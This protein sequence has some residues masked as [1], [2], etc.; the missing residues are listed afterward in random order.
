[1][2]IH[3]PES[4]NEQTHT[5]RLSEYIRVE[6]GTTRAVQPLAN[7]HSIATTPMSLN[8]SALSDFKAALDAH[9][10]VAIT[11]ANGKITYANDKFCAISKYSRKELLGKDHRLINSGH[12]SKEYI[13]DL[14]DTI[15]SGQIWKGE[16]KNRAKDGSTYW[17]DTTIV[18]FLDQDGKPTQYIAIRAEITE[19][20]QLE[21]KN[22]AIM[23]EL[24]AVNKELTNFA[25]VVSHDLKAPL[26]GISSLAGWL[27][28][29]Y[30]DQLGDEGKKQ[31]GLMANRV[32]R[33]NGLI[34]G[35][36]TYSRAGRN[37]EH[38]QTVDLNA[39]LHNTI[40]LLAPPP[41][42]A[43]QIATP[44]PSISMEP[45]KAQQIFQ[46]LLS[47]AIKF[48]DKPA[49]QILM[50]CVREGPS[51]HVTISDNGP[52]IESKYFD[53]I[54]EL[55]QT[56]N[57]RDALESTGVGLSIVKKILELEHQ[58]I[59]VESTP[60]IGTTFHFTL[61]CMTPDHMMPNESAR[62]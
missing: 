38:R 60:G 15:K 51:C 9:A 54:F 55:F 13:R 6:N 3:F 20:K 11:D 7:I 57:R 50:G 35:I 5:G 42:I 37:Q 14:W 43:I 8:V 53:K 10:I 28:D 25:Y 47:N 24:E 40:E 44:F 22:A 21:E 33:L 26:R 19:R 34:S 31:L 32:E 39:L 18:P 12:H 17:V 62:Q 29:D 52:G 2:W 48:M 58:K 30:G 16:L 59:W 23:Q 46:N 49:G 41:H 36:L 56:L 4:N 27:I 61:P 45:F 1:M